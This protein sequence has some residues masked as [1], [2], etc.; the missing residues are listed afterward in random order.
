MLGR[1]ARLACEACH[2]ALLELAICWVCGEIVVRGEECVSLG[3]CFW[4]RACYGCLFCGSRLLAQGV[5]VVDLY[6][7]SG[8]PVEN[9]DKNGSQRRRGE[10]DTPRESSLHLGKPL[11]VEVVPL[12]ANCVVEVELDKLDARS[13]L[14]RGLRRIDKVDGGLTRRRWEIQEGEM[15]RVQTT[16]STKVS[17]KFASLFRPQLD[18]K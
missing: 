17:F 13:V 10:K 18:F 11:K 7:D 14:Q 16:T 9:K 3:W 1:S 2:R 15:S 6:K 5:R 4:H 8:T 12:C